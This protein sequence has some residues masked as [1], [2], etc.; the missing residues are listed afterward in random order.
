M[1]AGRYLASW[2]LEVLSSVEAGIEGPDS[3]SDHRYCEPQ[4]GK[5]DYGQRVAGGGEE[6]PGLDKGNRN[7]GQWRPKAEK[8]Q[9]TRDSR[10]QIRDA[11]RQP[12][13]F[14]QMRG[15]EIEQN[16]AGQPALKQKTSARPAFGECGKETLQRYSPITSLMLVILERHRKG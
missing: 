14:K 9:Y 1:G 11:G 15:P 8:Q 10:N 13:V 16:R 12:S 6:Y 7:S 5:R 3:G 4:A 2:G